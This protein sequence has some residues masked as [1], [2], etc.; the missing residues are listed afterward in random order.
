MRN[1]H[2]WLIEWNA[3]DSWPG[4]LSLKEWYKGFCDLSKSGR[5][6]PRLPHHWAQRTEG[7]QA[8]LHGSPRQDHKFTV[9]MDMNSFKTTWIDFLVI[10]KDQKICPSTLKPFVSLEFIN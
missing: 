3:A 6:R 9:E 5:V 4:L 7:G 8:T 10:T 1:S 2:P